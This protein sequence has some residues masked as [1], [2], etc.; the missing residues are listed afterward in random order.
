MRLLTRLA[1]LEADS[2]DRRVIV[3]WQHCWGLEQKAKAR[4]LHD[5]PS[6]KLDGVGLA[7]FIIR[8]AEPEPEI[9]PSPTDGM[10]LGSH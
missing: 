7:V 2:R 9:S 10:A 1:R 3:M 5:H 6:E 8:W 4:W